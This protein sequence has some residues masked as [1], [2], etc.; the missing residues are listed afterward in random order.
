MEK[1]RALTEFLMSEYEA[2]GGRDPKEFWSGLASSGIFAKVARILL[3]IP[4]SS[5]SSERA[6]SRS[7]LLDRRA[8]GKLTPSNLSLST[9]L[10]INIAALKQLLGG[11]EAVITSIMAA[12][13]I[14]N[15]R[16]KGQQTNGDLT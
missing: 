10:A 5:A 4:A 9:M 13:S 7:G 11:T 1:D 2:N 15:D 3:S 8:N 6:F 12:V 14:L 16:Q